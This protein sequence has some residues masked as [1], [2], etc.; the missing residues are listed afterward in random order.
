MNTGATRG[1]LSILTLLGALVTVRVV[2]WPLAH[3]TLP[4]APELRLQP[5][6][7]DS[8][9]RVPPESLAKIVA[10]DPFRIGRRPAAAAYD[11]LRLT[12]AVAPRPP[13]PAI[14]LVGIVD[15][16]APSAVVEGFP[17]VDGSRVVRVGDIVSGLRVKSIDQGVAVIVGPD[18]TWV[19]KVREPWKN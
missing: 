19:L 18:T 6:A 13:R 15:G 12:V 9:A 10:R 17:G 5:H 3:T 14:I 2:A 4:P 8:V 1:A 7:A 11:P 16:T